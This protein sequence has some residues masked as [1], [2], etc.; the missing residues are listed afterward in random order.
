MFK[1]MNALLFFSDLLSTS[2]TLSA[3]QCA[4]IDISCISMCIN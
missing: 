3:F 2:L 1:E 4:S